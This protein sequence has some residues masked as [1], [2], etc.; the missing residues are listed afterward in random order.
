MLADAVLGI[1]LRG[2]G[3]TTYLQSVSVQG[4]K[5]GPYRNV[6]FGLALTNRGY[7]SGDPRR[8]TPGHRR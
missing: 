2:T 1:T 8:P 7:R 3:K 4:T 6:L 5:A